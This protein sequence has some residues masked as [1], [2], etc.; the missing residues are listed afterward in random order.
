MDGSTNSGVTD[1]HT[2]Y[3]TEKHLMQVPLS[4]G[5]I[6]KEEEQS[7]PKKRQRV[8]YQFL[9]NNSTRH[10]NEARDDLHCPWCAINCVHLYGLLKHLR[11]CHARF[12]FI[13]VVSNWKKFYCKIK[14]HLK[15]VFVLLKYMYI[16]TKTAF[17]HIVLN[18]HHSYTLNNLNCN[19][20]TR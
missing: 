6:S 3:L 11:L 17:E 7:T 10:Q 2:Q 4:S 1:N 12:N 14:I 13:Y 9:Y 19:L 8:F 18:L 15:K 5:T 16:N 20:N